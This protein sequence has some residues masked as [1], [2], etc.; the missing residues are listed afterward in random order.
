MYRILQLATEYMELTRRFTTPVVS[1]KGVR[2]DPID[3]RT[4]KT[5]STSQSDVA[6]VGPVANQMLQSLAL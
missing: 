4:A 1:I 2:V 3:E 5:V 6:V